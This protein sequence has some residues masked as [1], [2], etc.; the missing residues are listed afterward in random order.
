[1]GRETDRQID[2]ETKTERQRREVLS[3]LVGKGHLV[4][5]VIITKSVLFFVVIFSPNE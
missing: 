1:M 3:V 5:I 2:R 4:I